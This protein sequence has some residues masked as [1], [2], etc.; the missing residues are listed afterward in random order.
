MLYKK[1]CLRNLFGIRKVSKFEKGHTKNVFADKNILSI[2][3]IYYYFTILEMYKLLKY[4]IP[5]YL[6]TLLGL[7]ETN[8]RFIL[9]K[10]TLKHYQQNFIYQ[11][12]RLWNLITSNFNCMQNLNLNYLTTK[13]KVKKILLHMQSYCWVLL[14]NN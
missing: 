4:K 1:K 12:P 6:Y 14:I 7:N 11:G 2:Y 10:L 8:T 9:P 3:S 13:S 5:I